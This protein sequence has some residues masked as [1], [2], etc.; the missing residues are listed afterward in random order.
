MRLRNLKAKP[1][2]VQKIKALYEWTW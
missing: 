1:H 2:W